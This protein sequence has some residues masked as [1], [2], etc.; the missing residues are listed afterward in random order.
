MTFPT[1]K[2]GIIQDCLALTGNNLVNVA[3]DGSDEWLVC[4]AAYEAFVP[5]AL[6]NHDWK[7]QTTVIIP[8]HDPVA[9][10]DDL[11][12]DAYIK[13]NDCMHLIWV[14]L[15]DQ[16]VIYQIIGNKICLNA[17][18]QPP[19]PPGTTPGVVT[20][21]YVQNTESAAVWT[22]T[23]VQ[24]IRHAV[25]AGIYKGL[26]E[27]PERADKELAMARGVL[28][29][30][31]TRSDQEQPKRAMFNSRIAAARR[32]RRPWPPVPTGWGGSGSPGG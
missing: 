14:R 21:K 20:I 25:F 19:A 27:D 7:F 23:F 26:H 15:S 9:P 3:D 4:S 29:E 22:P 24:A 8:D 18:G 31:R 17:S 11:F 12:T 6:E 28:Q 5:V 30:A 13:P 16:P 32:I 1:D 10:V 2:L